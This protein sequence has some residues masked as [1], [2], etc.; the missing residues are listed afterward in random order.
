M[1]RLPPHRRAA[2][3]LQRTFQISNLFPSLTV[4]EN[5]LLAAQ[6]LVSAKF[7]MLRP[8]GRFTRL[9]DQAAAVLGD[10]GLSGRGD[11]AVENLSHGERR[12]LEIALA[13]IARP[14]VLLL[15]EPTAGL[16]PAE[17]Q[18]MAALLK[19]LDPA[20]TML[21]IEHDMD[22]ALE[23]A[24]H[25]LRVLH[26]GRV[27]ADGPREAVKADPV[28]RGSTSV[29]EVSAIHTYYGASHVLHGVSLAVGAGEVVGILGRNG[30]GKT[31][32]MRSIIGFTPPRE[33]AVRFKGEDV[34]ASRRTGAPGSAWRWCLRAGG[35]SPRSACARTSRWRGAA[36]RP[37]DAR[38]RL[39][40]LSAAG[41][42]PEEP[43]EQA[44]RRRATDARHRPGA[45][46]EP[47]PAP[48][49]RADGGAGAAHGPRGRGA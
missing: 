46:V 48:D 14:R 39:R 26:Y 3:G 17:S 4:L 29:L 9:R 40:G 12:Q 22:I 15:D 28:V 30:T 5:G 33:G 34:T 41:R 37:V 24:A 8:L 21:I 2:L 27:I 47:G 18:L 1:T 19:R 7:S 45:H 35:C 42:A 38:A 43:R 44:L 11:T 13:L 6:G 10:V 20:I 36:R 49:G 31:A 16:S 25:V 23:L 32:L